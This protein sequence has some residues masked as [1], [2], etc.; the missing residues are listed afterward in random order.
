MKCMLD[1]WNIL[2]ILKFGSDQFSSS[3]I[4]IQIWRHF[5]MSQSPLVDEHAQARS[6][7]GQSNNFRIGGYRVKTKNFLF[8]S[9]CTTFRADNDRYLL[10]PKWSKWIILI[11]LFDV[12]LNF[13]PCFKC[14]LKTGLRILFQFPR[15]YLKRPKTFSKNLSST[16]TSH[17]LV[18][19]ALRHLFLFEQPRR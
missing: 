11:L 3:V 15:S 1:G 14:V 4:S 16:I 2:S 7:P 6:T 13:K 18:F 5:W 19:W 17:K 12:N 9:H 10:L 8:Y